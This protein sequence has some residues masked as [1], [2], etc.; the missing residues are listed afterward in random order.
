MFGVDLT[1]SYKALKSGADNLF[2]RQFSYEEEEL[3]D[4]HGN[5]KVVKSRWVSQ[6][7][8]KDSEG[9]VSFEICSGSYSLNQEAKGEF[10]C[11]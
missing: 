5:P 2:E 10:H 3:L 11:L 4:K 9:Y 1:T 8:Y 6:V 7:A